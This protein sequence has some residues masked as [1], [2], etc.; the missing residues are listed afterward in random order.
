[1]QDGFFHVAAPETGPEA[2]DA[3]SGEGMAGGRTRVGSSFIP[4][5]Y[6][7]PSFSVVAADMG[8][9]GFVVVRPLVVCGPDEVGVTGAGTRFN[10]GDDIWCVVKRSGDGSLSASLETSPDR[11][12]FACVRVA[13]VDPGQGVLQYHAGAL[14]LPKVEEREVVVGA[15]Y[16]DDDGDVHKLKY[17]VR[18]ALV[19]KD[20]GD[21][22]DED[23]GEGDESE[24][25]T[26]AE[27]RRRTPVF[28]AKYESHELKVRKEDVRTVAKEGSSDGPG[29]GGDGWE[30]VF[31]A[32][33]VC[34]GSGG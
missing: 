28:E 24:W 5:T 8:N 3:S 32:E 21:D 20:P 16:D 9:G 11:E 7:L 2:R 19:V 15:K 14:V 30:T 31:T 34:T 10:F 13:R 22:E 33:P 25:K 23:G 1:M 26:L 6:S 17:R 4:V 27:L 18:K 12:A 29:S